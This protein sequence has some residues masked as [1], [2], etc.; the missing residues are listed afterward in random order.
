MNNA[1][2]GRTM[3]D[4]RKFMDYKLAT[5]ERLLR[6]YVSD[7]RLHHL[8]IITENLVLAQNRKT[9]VLLHQPTACG[10]AILELSKL[11]M[12]RF[13]S[14]NIVYYIFLFLPRCIINPDFTMRQW[15]NGTARKSC[16]SVWRILTGMTLYCFLTCIIVSIMIITVY[17][18]MWRQTTCSMTLMRCE[19][20]LIFQIILL[21]HHCIPRKTWK[22][23]ESLKVIISLLY[24]D[25]STLYILQSFLSNRW[26]GRCSN[27]R[28]HW[29]EGK[30]VQY[31]E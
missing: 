7:S 22:S 9:V 6:K 29:T 12:Y 25:G 5:S 10:F 28:V 2:Y 20:Y 15:W 8:D 21:L 17:S 11:L 4:T 30:I 3:M 26:A 13:V 16:S 27:S 18:I 24:M 31:L 1:I 19:I 23:L 14:M